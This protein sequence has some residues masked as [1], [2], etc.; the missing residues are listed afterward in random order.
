[1]NLFKPSYKKQIKWTGIKT[2]E[3]FHFEL[4]EDDYILCR[5]C[6]Y[7]ITSIENIIAVNGQH[8]HTFTNPAGITY[9]IGCFSSAEGC[10]IYGNHTTDFT[11]FKGF[12]W[13]YSLCSNCFFHL[14]WHYQSSERHFFGLILDNLIE[15]IRTH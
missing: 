10:L 7:K 4:K 8:K 11:W 6:R 14:G 1:M 9:E 5:N 3:E 2:H 15:N 12:S 13:C